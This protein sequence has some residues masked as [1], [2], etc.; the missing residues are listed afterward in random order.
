MKSASL[1]PVTAQ[2]FVFA[3]PPA[4]LTLESGHS[5]SHVTVAFETYG[6]LNEHKSNAIL[7]C[8][9]LSGDA[10]AA[11]ISTEDNSPG[12]W[13]GLIGPG[14]ALDTDKYFIV[15][16]NVLGGCR[17]SMGPSSVT[18]QSGK[19][20]ALDFPLITIADMVEAERNLIDS[21]GIEKLLC[22][23]GGSMGGMQ[24]LQWASAYPERVRAAIPIA[25][26]LKHSPQQ[27]A[28]DEVI[29]Q[30]IMADPAWRQVLALHLAFTTG[31]V[32]L[33]AVQFFVATLGG[34]INVLIALGLL[35]RASLEFRFTWRGTRHHIAIGRR[36][37]GY[38]FYVI[39]NNV[40]GGAAN[41]PDDRTRPNVRWLRPR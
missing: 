32:A 10:H 31:L 9:A 30:S 35:R 16:S 26:A 18:P 17:G 4:S 3:Q 39:V 21:F 34:A 19:P 6:N 40:S 7:V 41:A 33:A 8:H 2:F 24:A 20:Y 38:G 12:W 23:I 5:L 14:K 25:T 27:I 37:L 13:D 11:G 15:C 36:I 29:R 22:V 28:F 1:G